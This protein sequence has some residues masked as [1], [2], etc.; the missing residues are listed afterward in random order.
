M[1]KEMVKELNKEGAV[2]SGAGKLLFGK[3]FKV[4]NASRA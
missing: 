3:N 4:L 1:K 2:I